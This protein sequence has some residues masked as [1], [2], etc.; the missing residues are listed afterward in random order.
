MSRPAQ[1]R[2]ELELAEEAEEI[3]ETL[4]RT[5]TVKVI[6]VIITVKDRQL[7]NTVLHG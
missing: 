5:Y 3:S 1:S 7:V 2:L 4:S 6:G